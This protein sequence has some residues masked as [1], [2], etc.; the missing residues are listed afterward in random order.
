MVPKVESGALNMLLAPPTPQLQLLLEFLA[1]LNGSEIAWRLSP[2][3]ALLQHDGRMVAM[4]VIA[5]TRLMI[6]PS[7]GPDAY[8]DLEM[9]GHEEAAIE[10]I[11][12]LKSDSRFR[13][14][15]S[16]SAQMP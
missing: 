2:N 15:T 5:G 6:S 11:K 13:Q 4:L 12:R 14:A 10:F 1:G 16:S 9:P 7:D 3:G 8:F